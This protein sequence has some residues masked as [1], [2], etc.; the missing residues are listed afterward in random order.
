M[1]KYNS[2]RFEK[3]FYI[4]QDLFTSY[5]EATCY[6]KYHK[7]LF[8]FPADYYFVYLDCNAYYDTKTMRFV[9]SRIKK[10]P[11]RYLKAIEKECQHFLSECRRIQKI[12]DGKA[13]FTEFARAYQRVVCIGMMRLELE[14][15]LT[16]VL[17]K[18]LQKNG[19]N[20]E[21]VI[22]K[23][24]TKKVLESTKQKKE[25]L[26]LALKSKGKINA[27]TYEKLRQLQKRYGFIGMFLL[28]KQPLSLQDL[29]RQLKSY[30]NASAELRKVAAKAS[31]P[32]NL[33][34]EGKKI[35]HMLGEL[36]YMRTN[37]VE[38]I[39]K[40]I[41][42]L[43]PMIS[44]IARKMHIRKTLIGYVTPP[45]IM[46]F[47]R[48]G[49]GVSIK[50]LQQ[51]RKAYGIIGPE[52]KIIMGD[53]LKRLS[54]IA[55]KRTAPTGTVKGIAATTGKAEGA[56]RVIHTKSEIRKVKAGDIIVTEMTTPDYM[57]AIRN[58]AAI[59]TDIG[60]ITSHAAIVARELGIPCIVGTKNATRVIKNG[61]LIVVN[62]DNGLVELK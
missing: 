58:A 59:V 20:P 21:S 34:K 30:K 10:N 4:K 7:I 46:N 36:S 22:N 38:Q 11:E 19:L 33:D 48:K 43:L 25:L 42:L 14:Y 26:Q 31:V 1:T 40:G 2:G 47:L 56:A 28:E 62:A 49:K 50:L 15:V 57:A 44:R 12:M 53:K 61:Q 24:S 51:R 3:V 54:Q 35:F 8:G 55:E 39:N 32:C 45:E 27:A 52:A 23:I 13:Q 17:K 41:Y 18:R 6:R 60:G 9:R 29:V 37:S 16:D 5:M